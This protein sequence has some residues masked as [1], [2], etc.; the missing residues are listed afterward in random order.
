MK[1]NI[2]CRYA[3]TYAD[4]HILDEAKLEQD[5][6]VAS[7]RHQKALARLHRD[8][9]DDA[10][11]KIDEYNRKNMIKK[12]E[13][14]RA[15]QVRRKCKKNCSCFKEYFCSEHFWA[16]TGNCLPFFFIS[17]GFE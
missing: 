16:T 5:R 2:F 7:K 1:G 3:K 4:E 6:A 17:L 15:K 10:R 14:V 12:K 13:D 8:A 11:V 9:E